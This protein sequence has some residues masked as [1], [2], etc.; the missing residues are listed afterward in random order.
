MNRRIPLSYLLRRLV[1]L[2]PVLFGVSLV[3]FL[4]IHIT[5]GDPVRVI[6]GDEYQEDRAAELR[7][8]LGLDAPLPV[9]YAI[10][11]GRVVRGDLGQSAYTQEPVMSLIGHSLQLTLQLAA[12]SMLVALVIALPSGMISAVRRNGFFDSITRALTTVGMAVPVFWSGIMLMLIFGMY[13]RWLP[14]GGSPQRFGFQALILPSVALGMSGAALIAR[15]TRSSMVQVLG[16]KYM[17]TARSK[18][19]PPRLLFGRHA[20]RNALVPVITVVGLELGSLLGGAVLTERVFSLPGL[21]NL[22]VESI[23]RRDFPVIQGATLVVA[24]GFVLVNLLVD[25][26]YALVDPRIRY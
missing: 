23:Y 1:L 7:R 2:V 5:P 22:L 21:G 11:L 24:V 25:L 17:T 20:M 8:E 10:W 15:M 12:L 13:L 4:L 14:A 16:E 19:L 18:G 9:Q 3:T 26:S 6:L